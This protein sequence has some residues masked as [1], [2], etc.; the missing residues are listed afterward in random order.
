MLRVCARPLF[1][2]VYGDFT[3]L[4]GT[5]CRFGAVLEEFELNDSVESIFAE[6]S[7]Q[8]LEASFSSPQVAIEVSTDG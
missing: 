5:V 7:M 1:G 6:K 3:R 4:T 2:L 8:T